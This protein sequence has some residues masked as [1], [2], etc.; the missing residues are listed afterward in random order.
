[1]TTLLD[2][3]L[4]QAERAYRNKNWKSACQFY[5]SFFTRAYPEENPDMTLEHINILVRYA[6]ALFEKV[7]A[8]SANSSNKKYDQSE[9][10]TIV[11]YMITAQKKY[12]TAEP[13]TFPF[14]RLLDTYDILGQV[15]LINNQFKR[16]AQVF[17]KGYEKA[18][19]NPETPWRI[20]LSLLFYEAIALES[21]E[22]P[23]KAID[24]VN[25]GLALI[26]QQE[27]KT[28]SQEEL[29]LMKSFKDD[30]NTKLT[31]LQEDAKEQEENK[32]ILTTEEED[33]NEGEGE[34]EEEEE[35]EADEPNENESNVDKA[36]K[37]VTPIQPPE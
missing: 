22:I 6:T 29:D 9:L 8:D 28:T 34:E 26:A 23:K 11:S 12:E 14:E 30:L 32:D 31:Q 4:E 36:K 19:E 5:D 21:Q 13:G 16:A 15:A 18:N 17:R 24:V 35:E 1:M 3:F 37:D 33:E 20:K 10:E 25:E 7:Q 2:A 27:E